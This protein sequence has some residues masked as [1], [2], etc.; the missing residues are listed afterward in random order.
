MK[1]SL[2]FPNYYIHWNIE[3]YLLRVSVELGYEHC[4]NKMQTHTHIYQILYQPD[5]KLGT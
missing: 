5:M 2:G 1:L 3:I 4:E